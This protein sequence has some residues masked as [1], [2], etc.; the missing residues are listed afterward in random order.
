LR[1]RT[2]GKGGFEAIGKDMQR[3]KLLLNNYLSYDEMAIAALVSVAVPTFF[4]NAGNRGNDGAPGREG[5]YEN[6]GV[7]VGAVGARFEKP[8]LMEFA[9]MII[10]Q[11]QNTPANGYGK[12]GAR[13]YQENPLLQVWATFYGIDYF[14]SYDEVRVSGLIELK[15]QED[16]P[17]KTYLKVDLRD[18]NDQ[19]I[20]FYIHKDVY[21]KRMMAV[22]APYL[23]AA[24]QYAQDQ[25]KKAYCRATGLGLGVWAKH[26]KQRGWLVDVYQDAVKNLSLSHIAHIEFYSFG[27]DAVYD[28]SFRE[29]AFDNGIAISFTRFQDGI[30]P[31]MPVR[32]N[33]LLVAQYAWDGNSYPGNEYWVRSLNASGDPVA[34]CASSI[35]YLQNPDVNPEF[36]RRAAICSADQDGRVQ[37]I[38]LR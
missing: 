2:S 17:V 9:H 18:A 35:T 12:P 25:G 30:S 13:G 15:H 7:L 22:V 4:V 28:R 14:P 38:N 29:Q 16:N 23:L 10:T 37:V 11:E 26:E 36:T 19:P 6:A 32:E 31:F 34:A 27:F 24:N 1:D 20:R 8:G 3:E 5:S 33:Q 21:I